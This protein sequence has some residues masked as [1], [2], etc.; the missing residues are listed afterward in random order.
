VPSPS[1]RKA[2]PEKQVAKPPQV[3]RAR[4]LSALTWLA[5]GFGTR[6][7][8]GATA[9]YAAM[10]AA[11][12]AGTARKPWPVITLRQVHSDIIHSVEQ[13]PEQGA[14][15]AA[16][17]GLITRRKGL[18]LAVRTADCLPVI[19]ADAEHRAVGIF[20]AGWRGTLARLVEK[21]VG[22][23]RAQFGSRPERLRAALGPCIRS[24]CY[25]VGPEVRELFDSQ[26]SYAAAL[27]R[28]VF[29]LDPVRE[30]YPLL[31]LTARAPGHG[32]PASRLH[33]DLV[34]ANR[35]QLLDAGVREKNIEASE[36]CTACRT[37]L[38]HSYRR[39]K[40]RAGRMVTAVGIR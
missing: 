31:F 14:A 36:L 21:G 30:K 39:A 20:H 9:D 32:E 6:H 27:F 15:P 8:P 17:D 1:R 28:E 22:R 2:R 33:L 38:L 4:N 24:C 10:A 23:M 40:E 5:H 12:K 18:L 26:F 7:A 37:D 3:L 19:V 35:R 11:L 34:E 16:G 13:A 25:Q 29:D